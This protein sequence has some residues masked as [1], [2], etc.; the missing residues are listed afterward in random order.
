MTDSRI[1]YVTS[2][3]VDSA[4]KFTNE[5]VENY[6]DR[7]VGTKSCTNAG[8]RIAEEFKKYCDSKLL[9]SHSSDQ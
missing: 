2:G 8:K 9:R 4:L 6:P 7:L 5:I 1:E 3:N